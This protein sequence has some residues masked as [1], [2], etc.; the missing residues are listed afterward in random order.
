[1]HYF[2]SF[3][4]FIIHKKKG[5][6]DYLNNANPSSNTWLEGEKVILK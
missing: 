1:M 2:L 4:L 6:A 3:F 5:T